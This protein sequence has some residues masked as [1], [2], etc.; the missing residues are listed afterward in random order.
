MAS[1][2][3]PG[4]SGEM[5]SPAPAAAGAAPA[6]AVPGRE[7][8]SPP[9]CINRVAYFAGIISP[10]EEILMQNR[11]FAMMARMKLIRR[12]GLMFSTRDE[13]LS[14]HS[15]DTAFFMHALLSLHNRR[16]LAPGEE[17]LDLGE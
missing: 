16:F 13:N 2:N 17:P 1:L 11:F 4:I 3:L 10:P 7:R 8:P 5:R 12:W 6:A 9:P 15:L 14:E